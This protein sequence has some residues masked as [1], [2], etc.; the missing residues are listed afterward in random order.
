MNR[1]TVYIESSVVSYYTAR[2]SR[3]LLVLS[4]QEITRVWWEEH[5][6]TYEP[7][8]SGVVLQELRRGAVDAATLRLAAVS[9]FRML[10]LPAEVESLAAVYVSELGLPEASTYD[11]LHIAVASLHAVDYLVTW[12]C[13]HIANARLRRGLADINQR[14]GV[15]IP[16][17]CTPEELLNEDIIPDL[18]S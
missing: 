2:Q 8:I 18:I 13:K 16:V 17:I 1:P 9:D 10:P 15:S 3:D 5:L 7:C 14:M 4:H 11:A 12:N 6:D